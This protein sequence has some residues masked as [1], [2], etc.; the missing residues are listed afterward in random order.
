V[1]AGLAASKGGVPWAAIGTD[2]RQWTQL[3]G[4]GVV[5]GRFDPSLL[6]ALCQQ[7]DVR[8]FPAA[9]EGS[10]WAISPFLNLSFFP[11]SY[12]GGSRGPASHFVG[13]SDPDSAK[14]RRVVLVSLGTSFAPSS[15]EPM[16]QILEGAR[17]L[18]GSEWRFLVGDASRPGPGWE[19]YDVAFGEAIIAIG[20]GG[21]AFLWQA[22]HEGIPVVAIASGVGDQVFGAR[23][24]VR[25]GIGKAVGSLPCATAEWVAQAVRELRGEG[26][27]RHRALGL[28]LMLRSGGGVAAAATLLEQLALGRGPLTDC[29]SPRCCCI[30]V[31]L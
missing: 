11:P 26:A 24:A 15:R 7:M 14:E 27:L 21:N 12:Y 17:R 8:E 30:D 28:R 2:G 1:L 23:A 3:P 9:L 29:V 22:I 6:R 4:L 10:V 16:L 19:R 31:T 25:L 18:E 5:H 20:H 13:S